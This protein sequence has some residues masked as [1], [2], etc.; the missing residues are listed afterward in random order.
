MYVLKG[1]LIVKGIL[2]LPPL[3]T[4]CAKQ[5][6]FKFSAQESDLAYHLKVSHLYNRQQKWYYTNAKL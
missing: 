1:S 6:L 5:N 3:S 2:T 4:K